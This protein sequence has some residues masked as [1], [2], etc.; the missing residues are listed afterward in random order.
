LLDGAS[1]KRQKTFF[2][3]GDAFQNDGFQKEKSEGLR[4]VTHLSE[5]DPSVLLLHLDDCLAFLLKVT[6]CQGWL[7]L[8]QD[9]RA[10]L[11]L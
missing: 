6:K 2:R 8:K 11:E 5:T 9:Q 3:A 4:L 1:Q 7:H 10:H